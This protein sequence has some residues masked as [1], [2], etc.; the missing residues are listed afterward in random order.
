MKQAEQIFREILYQA[1][2]QKKRTLTQAGLSRELKLSLSAVNSAV[3][4]LERIGALEI[5][6]R[7]FLVL[8][9]KKILY[10]WASIRNLPRDLIY[11]T[12]VEAPVREI[13]KMLP[14][15]NIIYT[16][17][18][19]Y[20]L[21]FKEVPADYSEVYVYGEESI[22][23]RFPE[24]KGPPNFFVLKKDC[25]LNKYGKTTTL[26]HTFVDLW[27]LK[28]WYAKEFVKAWEEKMHGILE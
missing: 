23:E 2:E 12:R 20:K 9:L 18:S 3:K 1:M 19:A 10:Y 17:Y 16:A 15:N 8:D 21:K 26:A 11:A 4:T 28:E 13:E 27:N 24:R 22:K 25:S 14:D 6:Q 5:R 7:S